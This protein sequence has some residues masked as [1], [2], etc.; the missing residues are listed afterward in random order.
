MDLHLRDRHILITGGSKGIGLACAE[1]FLSEGARVTLVSRDADNLAR[2]RQKLAV[3]DA[4]LIHTHAA[5]L[6]DANAAHAALNAAEA[7]HGAVDVLVNSA[8]A[9]R[10]HDRHQGALL[11]SQWPQRSPTPNRDRQNRPASAGQRP[12]A[13]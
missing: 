5:D 3:H 11:L 10:R 1:A 13:S 4:S 7:A 6:R 12:F 9:A 2:A 8:G